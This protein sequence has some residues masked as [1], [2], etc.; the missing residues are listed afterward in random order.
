MSERM[1]RT[2]ALT[3]TFPPLLSGERKAKFIELLSVGR[4]IDPKMG[5]EC[6]CMVWGGFGKKMR[7]L[8]SSM[9]P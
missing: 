6:Y 7:P 2:N 8:K 9:W 1:E 5:I 4:S 3:K